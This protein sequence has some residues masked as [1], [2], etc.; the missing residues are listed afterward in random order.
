MASPLTSHLPPLTS[1]LS[2]LTSHL[3]PLTSHL[4]P[5]TSHLSPLASRLSPL[6]SHLSPLTS[7]LSPLA[8]HLHLGRTGVRGYDLPAVVKLL[9]VH[10]SISHHL[11]L[12]TREIDRPPGK[13]ECE[14]RFQQ[15][16]LDSAG[17]DEPHCASIRIPPNV[18]IM[19]LLPA[20]N[21]LRI[22]HD[23]QFR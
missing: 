22:D 14:I 1:H 5:L 11:L 8:S 19:Q 16:D 4:S 18:G 2:P 6:T 9:E 17:F 10:R 21:L 7:H 12:G 15:S 13:G 23:Q 3:S 20:I